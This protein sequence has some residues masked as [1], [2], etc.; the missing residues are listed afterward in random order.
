MKSFF[1]FMI[2]LFTKFIGWLIHP[3]FVKLVSYFIN[4]IHT[5]YIVKQLKKCGQYPMIHFPT[6]TTGLEYISIGDN[7]RASARL[8]L[9]SFDNL[10]G[11]SYIPS[12]KIGDNVNIS[13]DC[14]I[15]C[16]CEIYI[17]N[18]VLIASKVFITDHFHG[19]TDFESMLLPPNERK[20]ISKGSVI[21]EDN[22]WIGEGVCIMPNVKIGA[23]SIIGAN[24][25]VTKDI[26]PFSVV[27]GIP[28]KIIKVTNR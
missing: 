4:S 27:G 28:A 26:L 22:V 8:R 20:I 24:S 19:K 3:M 11:I 13:Y 2:E 7:F 23:N 17:G 21:I 18:N 16:I 9:E 5:H 10:L 25:V 14:H 1:K 12:L 15:C 6:N